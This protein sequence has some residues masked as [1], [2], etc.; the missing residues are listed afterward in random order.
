MK[1]TYIMHEGTVIHLYRCVFVLHFAAVCN[2]YIL[3]RGQQVHKNKTQNT[4]HTNVVSQQWKKT[5]QPQLL[6]DSYLH[7]CIVYLGLA[8]N[9]RKFPI[10]ACPLCMRL[11]WWYAWT[12]VQAYH[13]S[14]LFHFTSWG[15]KFTVLVCACTTSISST[16]CSFTFPCILGYLCTA[17]SILSLLQMKLVHVCACS[18]IS[19]C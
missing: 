17:S 19:I 5:M 10:S 12:I 9:L 6:V 2:Y 15:I 11:E 3:A 7:Q 8:F 18:S 1:L 13:H 4:K 16:T 14:R